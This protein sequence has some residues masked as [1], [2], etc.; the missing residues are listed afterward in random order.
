MTNN[1]DLYRIIEFYWWQTWGV[2]HMTRKL[3]QGQRFDSIE[4]ARKAIRDVD[5]MAADTRR[6]SE[7]HEFIHGYISN[8][9]ELNKLYP[10]RRGEVRFLSEGGEDFW[11]EYRVVPES[12]LTLEPRWVVEFCRLKRNVPADLPVDN[13][14]SSIRRMGE[15]MKIEHSSN[16]KRIDVWETRGKGRR[17]FATLVLGEVLA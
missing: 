12:H 4:A 8:E 10:I 9:L 6:D 13:I 2:T 7:Y 5:D 17:R 14:D 16:G 11:G 15:H 3:W 1:T